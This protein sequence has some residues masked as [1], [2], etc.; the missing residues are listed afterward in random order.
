MS[1]EAQR[2]DKW[3]WSARFIKSRSRASQLVN[4]GKVRRNSER[5]SKPGAKV[6]PGDVLTFAVHD[7]VRVIRII[8]L[9]ARRGPYS[10][11]ITLYEDLAPPEPRDGKAERREPA[12]FEQ[13]P[14]GAGRPTKKDRR[15]TQS[16]KSG[17]EG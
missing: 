10:E 3:L 13:R 1:E 8:E 14:R 11:A 12:G 9:A 5:I 7:A 16:L 17:G 6:K 15:V 4:S 2:I